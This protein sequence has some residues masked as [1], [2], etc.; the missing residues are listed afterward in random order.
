[1]YQSD[2]TAALFYFYG[3]LI[4]AWHYICV[5][6]VHVRNGK[7]CLSELRFVQRGIFYRLLGCN[8]RNVGDYETNSQN[9]YILRCH[10]IEIRLSAPLPYILSEVPLQLS[11][12]CFHGMRTVLFFLMQLHLCISP[13]SVLFYLQAHR[14]SSE[15][16]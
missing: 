12:F 8:Q 6:A 15:H 7:P 4:S 13:T 14:F 2:L 9:V 3:H 1:M 10:K 5:S 16:G 11:Y